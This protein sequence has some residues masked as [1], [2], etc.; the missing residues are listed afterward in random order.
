MWNKLIRATCLFEIF[1]SI[2]GDKLRKTLSGFCCFAS[3]AVFCVHEICFNYYNDLILY[4]VQM[5]LRF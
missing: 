1:K 5:I 2:L 4:L 3:F